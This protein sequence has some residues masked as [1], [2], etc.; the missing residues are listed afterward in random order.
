MNYT[1]IIETAI[2]ECQYRTELEISKWLSDAFTESGYPNL[3]CLG[4]FN[5]GENRFEGVLMD[6]SEMNNGPILRWIYD[7]DT[8]EFELL[9]N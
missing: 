6:G 3:F 1:E 7:W 9:E 5:G 8:D 4:I 2:R